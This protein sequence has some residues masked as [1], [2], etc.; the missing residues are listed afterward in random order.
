MVAGRAIR[1][2]AIGVLFL[3]LAG[4]AQASGPPPDLTRHADV[5]DDCDIFLQ[6]RGMIVDEPLPEGVVLV[7]A[8]RCLL[9]PVETSGGY[10]AFNRVRQRAD[11]GL[12]ALATAM[13]L[14]GLPRPAVCSGI[15]MV[16]GS[17]VMTVTDRQGRHY[18][19]ALPS[20]GCFDVRSEVVA[21]V[22]ALR[23]QV[24]STDTVDLTPTK[25]QMESRCAG[26]YDAAIAD[27]FATE[28]GPSASP[29]VVPVDPTQ[30][31]LQVCQYD[32]DKDPMN[33]IQLRGST[34]VRFGRLTAVSTLDGV[35]A[36][37]FWS[38]VAAAAR[39]TKPCSVQAAFTVVFPTAGGGGV[40]IE[41]G[42]CFREYIEG[43]NF[44]R[45]L[46]AAT[47]GT[48]LPA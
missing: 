8:T 33:A 5:G 27:G 47:V 18:R 9:Q 21:A 16:S 35:A 11:G 2:A 43:E 4:C 1:V 12:D 46:D 48:V 36:V 34:V 25:L 26:V 7:S 13:R 40:E 32:L 28:E 30:Q 17:N 31:P 14:P 38:T 42:G 22:N 6:S 3:V 20:Q 41:R 45:Q 15:G 10:R 23:W 19:P 29:R 44:L 24:V 39:V 37:Q